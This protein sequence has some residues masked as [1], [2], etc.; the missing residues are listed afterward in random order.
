MGSTV[1]HCYGLLRYNTKK[2]KTRLPVNCMLRYTPN[3]C[4]S[5]WETTGKIRG[6]GGMSFAVIKHHQSRH[7]DE[8]KV[9]KSNWQREQH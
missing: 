4:D 2:Q 5:E 6:G 3:C 9:L 1:G 8:T 7:S